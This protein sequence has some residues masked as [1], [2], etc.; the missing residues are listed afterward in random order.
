MPSITLDALAFAWTSAV[1]VL[2]HTS[3]HLSPGWTGVV[4]ANGAGKSTLLQLLAGELRPTGGQLRVEPAGALIHRCPQP[5]EAL[6]EAIEAFAWGW[7]ADAERLKARL[8]LDPAALTR[9]DT[10]SP[11]ERKRWQVGAAMASRADVL[12]LD[13][14][15]NHLDARGLRLLRD[16]LGEHR[17]IGVLV[18]HHEF[19]LEALTTATVRVHDGDARLYPGALPEARRAWEAEAAGQRGAYERLDRERRKLQRR[20]TDERRQR[21]DA[22]RQLSSRARMN[23]IHDTD[24]RSTA[25]K[26][27]AASG[28]AAVARRVGL[29]RGA[30][31]RTTEAM[32]GF[33]FDK[34]LGR[35]LFVDFEPPPMP[36]LA[37]LDG[38]DITVGGRVLLADVRVWL[39]RGARVR[40]TGDNG[41]GKTSLLRA[42]LDGAHLPPDRVLY[43]PQELTAEHAA[44]RRAEALSAP[45]DLRGRLLQLVAALGVDPERLRDTEQPSPGEARKLE[46]AFGLAGRAWLLVLDEP[47]NHLDLPAIQSLEAALA[48]WPGTL[49]LVSHDEAFAARCTSIEWAVEHGKVIAR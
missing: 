32:A 18:C 40:L 25:A 48:Q 33:T 38:R 14:P 39:D 20:L 3:L 19:F 22:E 45:H 44:R 46:I 42:L 30:L 26:A 47:T 12:L 34:V 1:P 15:T 43:V 27:R 4:G 49:L 8:E 37:A 11:G 31:D 28:E 6:T 10:L 7:E 29:T 21:G 36:R 16:A 41:A 23:G 35:S 17:G 2:S 5:V 24:A 13:E 9:W